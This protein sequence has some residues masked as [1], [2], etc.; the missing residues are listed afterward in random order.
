MIQNKT[1]RILNTL[2]GMMI[3]LLFIF[4]IYVMIIT[5]FKPSTQ[6]FDLKLWPDTFTMQSYVDVVTKYSFINAVKNSLL[7]AVVTTAL[8]LFLQTTSAFA[9]ARLRFRGKNFVFVVILST[10]MVPFSVILIPLFI[11]V[12]MIGLTN[13]LWGIIVPIAANGYGVFLMRQ[14]F[15]TL[16]KDLDE[17][18]CMDGASFF[19]IYWKILLPL[20]KPILM[21]LGT[22]YFIH[23][24]NNYMWPVVIINDS[25]KWMIQIAISAFSQEHE[26]AWDMIFAATVISSIPI[27]LAFSYFQSYIVEGIKTTGIK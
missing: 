9:F 25:T 2:F 12:K 22:A 1:T 5:S 6:I 19:K 16:P 13:S 17:S 18:A 3:G 21:T 4:P 15:L 10:M 14:F 23:N 24:W 20:C 7:V 27:F 11:I 8:S 26:I